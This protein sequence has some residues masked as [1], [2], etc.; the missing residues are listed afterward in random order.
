M[1]SGIDDQ[2][3]AKGQED[4]QGFE[5]STGQLGVAEK[6]I[7]QLFRLELEV[8]VANRHFQSFAGGLGGFGHILMNRCSCHFGSPFL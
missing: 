3:F 2:I 5:I 8:H 1:A 6:G 4:R 7:V